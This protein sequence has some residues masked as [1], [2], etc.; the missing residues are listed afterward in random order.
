MVVKPRVLLAG[1]VFAGAI[2]AGGV[3]LAAAQTNSPS[4]PDTTTPNQQP[5]NPPNGGYT[6]DQG[7][8]HDGHNCPNMGGASNSNDG[9]QTSPSPDVENSI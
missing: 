4:A 2:A 5:A 6:F 9:T 7:G 3:S 1:A 8:S